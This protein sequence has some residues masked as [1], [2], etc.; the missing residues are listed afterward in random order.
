LPIEWTP[1]EAMESEGL[2]R[3]IPRAAALRRRGLAER[4]QPTVTERGQALCG[5]GGDPVGRVSEPD[6]EC[7]HGFVRAHLP[8]GTGS[9]GPQLCCIRIQGVDKRAD[10]GVDSDATQRARRTDSDFEARVIA[11]HADQ[12]PDGF[13]GATETE[14]FS[15]D[16]SEERRPL[17]GDDAD[18][19]RRRLGVQQHERSGDVAAG[20]CS[21]SGPGAEQRDGTSRVP[22]SSDGPRSHSANLGVAVVQETYQR[23]GCW[24]VAGGADELGGLT[25]GDQ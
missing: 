8:Q 17:L 5:V 10:G 16:G 7:R 2:P 3:V 14:H 6:D 13:D 9:D 24:S 18:Q 19:G 11:E 22:E 20:Q 1:A 4:Q 21:I 12:Q 15:S 23:G 25:S